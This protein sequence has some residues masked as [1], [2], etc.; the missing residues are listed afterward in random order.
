MDFISLV[1]ELKGGRVAAQLGDDFKDL[2][3]AVMKHGRKGDLTLKLKV[4]PARITD[5]AVKEVEVGYE[6]KV[7]T[8]KPNHGHT[9]FFTK[10]DAS[11]SRQDPAQSEMDFEAETRRTQ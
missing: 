11:L 4:D 3:A 5:G 1:A 10:E 8:P 2:V 7:T 9:I 6:L